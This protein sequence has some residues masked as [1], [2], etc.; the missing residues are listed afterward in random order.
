[1]LTEFILLLTP[2]GKTAENA[3]KPYRECFDSMPKAKDYIENLQSVTFDDLKAIEKY[4]NHVFSLVRPQLEFKSP[5]CEYNF[6]DR[7]YKQ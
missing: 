4:I 5:L 3:H 7:I 2:P 1:M 6:K